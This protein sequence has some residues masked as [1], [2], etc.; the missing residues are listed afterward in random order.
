MVTLQKMY[1]K[2]GRQ[3]QTR[4]KELGHINFQ[5]GMC[6]ESVR[7]FYSLVIIRTHRLKHLSR[8]L[9]KDDKQFANKKDSMSPLKTR[10]IIF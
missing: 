6:P 4:R 8:Y 3:S 7:N 2:M 10:V 1:I 5:K 9:S